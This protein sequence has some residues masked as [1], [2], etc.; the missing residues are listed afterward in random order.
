MMLIRLSD[1]HILSFAATNVTTI[2]SYDRVLIL[3]TM[4][5]QDDEAN[6]WSKENHDG[7]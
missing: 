4:S 7:Q 1:D 5:E 6:T 3:D 2:I